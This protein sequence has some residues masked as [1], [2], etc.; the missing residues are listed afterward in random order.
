MPLKKY[1]VLLLVLFGLLMSLAGCAGKTKHM[2]A[3]PSDQI[4]T[5]PA[6]GKSMIIFMR[7]STVGFAIQSSVFEVKDEEVFLA[8]IVAAKKKVAYELEP[9]EH[10]FMVVGESADFMSAN[11]EADK[12][13]YAL[14][15][16][17]IGMWKARFSLRPVNSAE[18]SSSEFTEWIKECEW[19]MKS[20]E[21][22]EWASSNMESIQEKRRSYYEKWK[23]KG[24]HERPAL[25]PQD[26]R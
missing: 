6:A 17:R 9:G 13:Y 22:E 21:S 18:L 1:T 11:L 2:I 10:L 4:K 12:T 23:D 19:V 3:M 26:G 25:I 7:P 20:S 14:V 8:G 15:T 16:P 24:S 5:S